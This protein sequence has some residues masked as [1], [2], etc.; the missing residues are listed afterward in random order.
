VISRMMRRVVVLLI[1]AMAAGASTAHGDAQFAFMD[2]TNSGFSA[3]PQLVND[4]SP[5]WSNATGL[6]VPGVTQ[7]T[8]LGTFLATNDAAC[9]SSGNPGTFY[10]TWLSYGQTV[11]GTSTGD[12]GVTLVDWEG[13]TGAVDYVAS[14]PFGGSATLSCATLGAQSETQL[15]L[16]P[17]ES[18]MTVETDGTRCV[19]QW[20][21]GAG[22]SRLARAAQAGPAGVHTRFVDSLATIRGRHALVRIQGFGEMGARARERVVLRTMSGTVVGRGAGTVVVGEPATTVRVTLDPPTRRALARGHELNV[23]GSVTRAADTPGTGDT[24][25]Q[26]VVRARR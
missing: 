8:P 16:R 19:T 24:I 17:I 12:G 11:K 15:G 9:Q 7:P 25:R 22:P 13:G 5:C 10:S 23:R 1:A 21:P 18:F 2:A 14:D 6:F 26:L 20:L 4:G 3:T